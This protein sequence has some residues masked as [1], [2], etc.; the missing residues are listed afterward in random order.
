MKQEFAI[1]WFRRDLRLEDNAGLYAALNSGYQV[2]PLF[3]FDRNILQMLKNTDDRRLTFIHS[4]LSDMDRKLRQLGCG[5]LTTVGDPL[6]IWHDLANRYHI[7]AVYTNHDYEPYAR[8]RDRKVADFL[9][10]ESIPF[11][12]FKDQVIFERDEVVKDDGTPYTVF[13]PYSKRF[14]SNL[15]SEHLREHPSEKL[16]VNFLQTSI[17]PLPTLASLGFTPVNSRFK[18]VEIDAEIIRNY[19]K[20]RDYPGIRG[21]SR[22]STHLRFGTISIRKLFR[23][24]LETNEKFASELIWR[25]FY[26]QILWHFPHVVGHA[27]RPEYDEI[28]WINNKQDFQAWC[29]GRTGYPLVDAGMRELLATGYMHNRVRM[30]VASFLTKHLLID[31][32]WGEAWFAQHLLDFELASNNGGWQWAA[33]CGCDA[34][35]YFR[36]FNPTIQAQKFDPDLNYIKRWV[37]EYATPAYPESIVEHSFARQRTQQFY[38][39]ALEK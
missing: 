10:S 35:P 24:A 20:T 32:R 7:A 5:M 12:T 33:G 18:P 6:E 36:V 30:V 37:P 19:H 11:H 38:K 29:E 23:M 1:F 22:L 31:W 14:M 4:R 15:R 3:I 2:L 16:S 8:E 34:A 25:E 21:T 27:F 39:V 28:E 13:T 26:Q 9:A 17:P